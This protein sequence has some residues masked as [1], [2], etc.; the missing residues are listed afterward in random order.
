MRDM[1][2]AERDAAGRLREGDAELSVGGLA[3]QPERFDGAIGEASV[4]REAFSEAWIATA[5]R[6]LADPS[7]FVR[8][9]PAD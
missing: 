1:S 5:A 6:N 3:G 8:V 4:A 7:G 9:D 2:K